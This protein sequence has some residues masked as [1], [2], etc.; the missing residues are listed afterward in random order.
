MAFKLKTKNELLG[1]HE[2]SNSLNNVIKEIEMP[3]KNMW[4]FIDEHKTIHINKNLSDDEKDLVIA[5]ETVHK[6]QMKD[7]KLKFD[8]ITYTWKD[9]PGMVGTRYPTMSI[10]PKDKSLPWENE[11]YA[12]MYK[13]KREIKRKR[14]EGT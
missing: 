4:G 14:N 2:T 1:L 7:G 10:N 6:E 13:I 11:A 12:S 8:S 9:K 3:E 5:H